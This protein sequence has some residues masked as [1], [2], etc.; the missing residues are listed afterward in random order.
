VQERGRPREDATG[1]VILTG[2][3]HVREVSITKPAFQEQH[4]IA[5]REDRRRALAVPPRHQA[6]SGLFVRNARHLEHGRFI[7]AT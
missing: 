1:L 6:I 2:S 3:C 4:A 7:M 5:T